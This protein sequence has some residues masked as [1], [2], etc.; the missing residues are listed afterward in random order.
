MKLVALRKIGNSQG[1]ILDKSIL[2]LVDS[3]APG[4]VFKLKVKKGAI[5][6]EPLSEKD[7]EDLVLKAADKVTGRQR[8]ILDKL[9][10]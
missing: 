7:K 6:L 8:T 4:T 9:S 10:K 5:V 1:V 3:S 2:D